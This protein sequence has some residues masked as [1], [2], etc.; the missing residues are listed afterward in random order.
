MA[1][2]VATLSSSHLVVAFCT[3]CFIFSGVVRI[4]AHFAS[5]DTDRWKVSSLIT[6][7]GRFRD[8]WLIGQ[9]PGLPSFAIAGCNRVIGVRGMAALTGGADCWWPV[10]CFCCQGGAFGGRGAHVSASVAITV[11]GAC[12]FAR[13]AARRCS[14]SCCLPSSHSTDPC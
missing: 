12:H 1:P 4:A 6:L 8:K 7:S 9:V 5:G 11:A 10:S 3:F 14:G 2:F 13:L